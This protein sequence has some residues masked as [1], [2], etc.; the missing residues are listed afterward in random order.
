ML[1]VYLQQIT[2]YTIM[3][4]TCFFLLK[5]KIPQRSRHYFVKFISLTGCLVLSFSTTSTAEIYKWTDSS[6]RTHYSD[7]KPENE[8]TE[9]V[10]AELNT[11][12]AIPIDQ[13]LLDQL[14]KSNQE[15]SDEYALQGR[16]VVMY[17]TEWCGNCKTA[18]K[19]FIKNNIPFVEYD[20]EKDQ[21]AMKR[22]QSHKAGGVP[23]ILF[24]KKKI[25][26]F[27]KKKFQKI[28]P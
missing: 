13:D 25:L 9:E 12:S 1:I 18:R 3:R 15:R 8:T 17:T 11:Y 27:N 14:S 16:K 24:G 6:G 23:L 7:Q 10:N 22:Y 28:Y 5:L 26:G 19:Y 21:R 4:N 2:R 20:I